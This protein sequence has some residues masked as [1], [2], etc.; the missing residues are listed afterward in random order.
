MCDTIIGT[1]ATVY[2]QVIGE[3]CCKCG[4]TNIATSWHKNKY[5]CAHYVGGFSDD[6]EHLH[7][8][9]RNCGYDWSTRPH[10]ALI[11]ELDKQEVKA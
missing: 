1:S 5:Q 8:T 10:N 3:M 2:P 11:A 4:S 7:K 6:S 9:C